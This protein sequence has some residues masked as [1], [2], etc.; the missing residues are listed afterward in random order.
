MKSKFEEK[1]K[2]NDILVNKIICYLANYS[3]D[4]DWDSK[5]LKKTGWLLLLSIDNAYA[6]RKE[7][8]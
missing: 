7:L 8:A 3:N 4:Q 5:M 6:Y 2:E 1:S